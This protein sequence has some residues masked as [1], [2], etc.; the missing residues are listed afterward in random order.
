[1]EFDNSEE[2]KKRA[3]VFVKQHEGQATKYLPCGFCSSN[4][5]IQSAKMTGKTIGQWL[6]D[7]FEFGGNACSHLNCPSVFCSKRLKNQWMFDKH[8]PPQ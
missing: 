6:Y 4:Y 8:I 5:V 7:L 3:E 2:S 1:M